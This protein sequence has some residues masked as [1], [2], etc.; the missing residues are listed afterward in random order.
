MIPSDGKVVGVLQ[1]INKID[2]QTNTFIPFHPGLV[3]FVEALAS[4]AAVALDNLVLNEE[5]MAQEEARRLLGNQLAHLDRQRSMENMS[6]SL[7]HELS[8]PL[9][10]I[11]TNAQVAKRG[12]ASDNLDRVQLAQMLDKIV[13]NTQRA[14]QI[15]ERIRGYI[16]PTLGQTQPVVLH[17]IILEVVALVADDA[18]SSAILILLPLDFCPVQVLGD[19]VQLSQILLN[20]LRNSMDALKQADSREIHLSIRSEG[21]QAVV[22][23][24]DTGPGLSAEALT[25]AG[26]PFFT[27]KPTGLG[28]GICISRNIASQLSGTLTISNAGD[29]GALVELRLPMITEIPAQAIE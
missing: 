27:T 12:L 22:T 10:A 20:M 19:P 26:V 21:E 24:R 11:L 5:R 7:G 28:M 8:Q 29:G 4:Q 15:V 2:P 23:I 16:R 13:L 1:F 17:Q 3:A 18:R 14:S 9:T 6:A 25:Q